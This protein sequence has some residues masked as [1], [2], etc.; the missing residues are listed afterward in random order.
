MAIS[1]LNTLILDVAS[2][3]RIAVPQ[4]ILAEVVP[5]QTMSPA[6]SPEGWLLGF[7][8][9]RGE[10]VPVIDPGVICGHAT[11]EVAAIHRYGV[12]YALEHIVGLSYY[13]VPLAAIP[14][15]VRVSAEEV[16]AED[17]PTSAPCPAIAA[18]A[19]IEGQS[20]T[21]PDFPYL[22]HQLEQQLTRL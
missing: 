3:L 9:W 4:A 21:I 1:K 22:E 17:M 5:Q 10:Q 8:D 11:P 18:M 20:V 14:H 2:G 13:A 12:L 6:G 16:Q 19:R 15:P 7:L